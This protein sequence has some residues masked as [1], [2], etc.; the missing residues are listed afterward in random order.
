[1][2]VRAHLAVLSSVIVAAACGGSA[3]PPMTAT[4][5]PAASSS[6]SAGAAPFAPYPFPGATAPVT[7]D[8][9]GI[10][11]AHG[12]VWV[13][14]GDTG[15]VD[16]FDVSSRTFARV[17]GFATAEREMRGKKRMAGPSSIAFGEGQAYVGDRAT[18]E[19]C[20]V[21]IATTKVGACLK[22]ASPPDGLQYVAATREL[23]VTTP[24]A[25]TLTIL[26]ASS[27]ATLKPKSQI[28]CG[29][30]PEGY[31]IDETRGLFFTNL[32]DKGSTLAIDVKTYAIKSTWQPACGSDGPRGLA[33][34]ASKGLVIVACTDHL[35]VLDA[36]HDG[37]LRGRL[38][39]GA[40]VDNIDF[41]IGPRLVVAAAGK[42]ARL[43]FAHLDEA[44]GLT[45]VSTVATSEGTRNV[46]ADSDGNA[47][48][49]D[50]GGAR[51]LVAT[52]PK[53]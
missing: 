34:D 2:R 4:T 11:R 17:D 51:L 13:P 50:A 22:L 41:A 8:Y 37:A 1:M 5:S 27:P 24:K 29:G 39:T 42:A 52:A 48:V 35:Q 43:T 28:N 46:V 6:A 33:V 18:S 47:Y 21:D 7:L 15:S 19:V 31:G 10:D 9:L 3:P 14:V 30:E 12:K 49:A 44:G 32:E 36:S 26:D 38:D 23:W 25:G 45:V 53:R 20:A 40:G 16:L